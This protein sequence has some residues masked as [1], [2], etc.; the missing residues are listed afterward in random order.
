[1]EN[2]PSL[3]YQE[4][5]LDQQKISDI[6]SK[7]QAKIQNFNI[8]V[9]RQESNAQ[10]SASSKANKENL[11][12]K[13]RTALS[14][15]YKAFEDAYQFEHSELIAD[16]KNHLVKTAV[17]QMASLFASS[18][19][20]TCY[21]GRHMDAAWRRSCF[22]TMLPFLS[23]VPLDSYRREEDHQA[24]ILLEKTALVADGPWT[25]KYHLGL[26]TEDS[27][28]ASESKSFDEKLTALANT[29][30]LIR[31]SRRWESQKDSPPS[32]D[33]NLGHASFQKMHQL[34]CQNLL[35]IAQTLLHQFY[36][37]HK[38]LIVRFGNLNIKN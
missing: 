2:N 25:D 4:Y 8:R 14:S 28:Q 34:R 17:T 6:P 23:E 31:M 35:P 11:E 24:N 26:S 1:M 9:T 10:A 30:S 22:E 21:K 15:L 19:C 18:R 33:F 3:F 13:F 5:F 20:K 16:L 38:N 32:L 36:D 7:G 37:H 27:L 12:A 29:N